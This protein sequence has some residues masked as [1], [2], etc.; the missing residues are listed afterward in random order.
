MTRKYTNYDDD[1]KRMLVELVNSG[2][3]INHE[4]GVPSSIIRDWIKR[5]SKINTP[6]LL[7]MLNF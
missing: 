5:F 1:F 7:N 6:S 4:Y 3:G 2:K